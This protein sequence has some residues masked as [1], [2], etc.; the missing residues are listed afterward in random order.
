MDIRGFIEELRRRK[1]IRVAVVYAVAAFVVAQVADILLP[2]LQLPDWSLTLVLTLLILGFPISIA[3][4]WAFDV[5]PAGAMRTPPSRPER[6]RPSAR[7]RSLAV[8]PFANTSPDRDNEYFSDGLAEELLNALARL[9]GLRVPARTSSFAFKGRNIDIR[10]IGRTLGVD[11]VLEGSVRKAGARL[12]ITAQLIDVADG[13]HRWSA[14][15]D[16]ELSDVFAIQEE[17]TRAI[18]D[19]LEFALPADRRPL[20]SA[21]STDPKAYDLYLHG[22]HDFHAFVKNYSEKRLQTALARFEE[23][24]K[25]DP[26]FAPAHAWHAVATVHLADDFLSPR[27]VYPRARL[28]AE[29]A[30]ELDPQLAEAHAVKGGI[31][32]FYDRDVKGAE[33]ALNRAIE[34]NANLV[35]ARIYSA[36]L[37]SAVRR[38]DEAIQHARYAMDVDPLGTLAA[39]GLGWTL[40]RA[41]EFDAAAKHARQSIEAEPEDAVAW[42][43]LGASQLEQNRAKEALDSIRQATALASDHQFYLAVLSYAAARAG[44][45]D[46]ARTLAGRLEERSRERYVPPSEIAYAHVGLGDFDTA[47]QWLERAAAERDTM[48]VFLDVEPVFAPLRGDRR[49]GELRHKAGLDQPQAPV[50]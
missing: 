40:Y 43:Q 42:L 11:S 17:I 23:S 41:G 30:L 3:L 9:E 5:T 21:T 38:H 27:E 36:L 46:E 4:A 26:N 44:L 31:K 49:Y 6:P 13:Y 19:A 35:L 12:R 45:V 22:L 20:V 50:G 15:F 28:S 10:E 16:R 25:Q 39:W 1:V 47:F 29:R 8:L 48:L 33:R 14:T 24:V 2:G 32:L 37:L 34:L 7:V 18:V